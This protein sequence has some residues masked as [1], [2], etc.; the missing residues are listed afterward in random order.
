MADRKNTPFTNEHFAAFCEKMLGQPYW[1][2]CVVYKCSESLRSRKAAQYPSHYSTS[3]TARYRSDVAA[4]KVCADCIGAAKGYSWTN[5][6]VGVFESIGTDK[7]LTNKYGANGC[8]DKSANGMFA[9]AKS[10]GT[11]WGTIGTLPE[12]VGLALHKDGHVGYYVGNGYAVE[13]RG[14]TYGCVRTKVSGRGWQYWYRLPFIHYE[15]ASAPVQDAPADPSVRKLSYTPG[16]AMP[17][18]EDVRALQLDLNALGYACGT[19]D[20]IFGPKTSAAVVAFQRDHGLEVDGIVGKQTRAALE[21]AH[22]SSDRQDGGKDP[23]A[24]NPSD[25]HDEGSASVGAEPGAAVGEEPDSDEGSA[26]EDDEEV[27]VPPSG[28]GP[29]D[30]GTRLLRYRSGKTMM[31]GSDVAAVQKRLIRLGYD[32]GKA[33]GIYGPNTAAAVKALQKA[34]KI[35]VDGAVGNDTR[36]A[37][38][39]GLT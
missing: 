16:K 32:P 33:D 11:A 9:Y 20:G 34:A 13:W 36:K 38:K 8:P 5:G 15:S 37:L 39:D 21:E 23:Q 29:L 35:E 19:A 3:R 18:G 31:T 27:Y 10:K 1:Y 14:F 17:R 30:Y 7:P 12:I 6:G 2:G 25:E 26:E 4:K 24:Q 28:E 22:Q